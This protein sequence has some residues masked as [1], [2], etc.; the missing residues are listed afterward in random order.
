MCMS[1]CLSRESWD[2][3]SLPKQGHKLEM[4]NVMKGFFNNGSALHIMG[5]WSFFAHVN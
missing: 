4:E 1:S 2:V 5:I 3:F